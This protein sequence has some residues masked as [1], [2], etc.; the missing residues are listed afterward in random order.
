LESIAKKTGGEM[1]PAD[2]LEEFARNL[3]HRKA[4]VMESSTLPL[5]H[6]PAMFGFALLCFVMEW[7][8]RRWKGMP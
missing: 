4:P 3:P 1:V 8:L 5:W 7:G 2:K 6:T